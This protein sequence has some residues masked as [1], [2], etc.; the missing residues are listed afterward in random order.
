MSSLV[1]ERLLA[2]LMKQHADAAAAGLMPPLA[3]PP[4]S[5]APATEQREAGEAHAATSV[6]SSLPLGVL[7][8]LVSPRGGFARSAFILPQPSSFEGTP[9]AVFSSFGVR[10][11]ASRGCFAKIFPLLM[12]QA[13]GSVTLWGGGEVGGSRNLCSVINLNH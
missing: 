10:P 5:M 13:R 1:D 4:T 8:T 11:R 6:A 7:S 12:S 9:E 3:V 2:F